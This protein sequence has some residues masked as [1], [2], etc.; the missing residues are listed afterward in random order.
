P[1]GKMMRRWVFALLVLACDQIPETA[2][3]ELALNGDLG[4]WMTTTPLTQPMT[5]HGGAAVNGFLYSIGGGVPA[6]NTVLMAQPDTSTGLISAWTTGTA[7]PERKAGI[8]VTAFNG[9]VYVAGGS[10]SRIAQNTSSDVLYAQ[11]NASGSLGTWTY[12][13]QMPGPRRGAAA[14]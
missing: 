10:S 5:A 1:V 14:T 11:V 2:S 3:H 13:P 9:Y 4:N 6:T 8:A 7:L 12:G